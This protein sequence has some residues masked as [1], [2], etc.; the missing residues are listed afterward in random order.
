[1]L[2]KLKY[3]KSPPSEVFLDPNFAI[4]NINA[5]VELLRKD[6][7]CDGIEPINGVDRFILRQRVWRQIFPRQQW[8]RFFVEDA[9]PSFSNRLIEL[10][11]SIPPELRLEKAVGQ[12]LLQ[13]IAPR[14]LDIDYQRTLMPM[15][16]P[17]RFW[18]AAIALEEKREALYRNI[19]YEMKGAFFIPYNRYYSNFDEWQRTEPVWIKEIDRLLLGPDAQLPSRFVRRDWLSRII[20]EQR[21]GSRTHFAQINVLVSVEQLLRIFG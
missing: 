13:Q 6:F 16:T 1:V 17:P 8:S 18:S 21:E 3:F 14:A 2:A 10:L 15:K 19:F 7:D 12:Q 5:V 20:K 9:S 4:D 11:L